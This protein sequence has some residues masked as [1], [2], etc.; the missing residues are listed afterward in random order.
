[1]NLINYFLVLFP[2][3]TWA[4][5]YSL[6][7]DRS[8]TRMGAFLLASLVWGAYLLLG[9]EIL[10]LFHALTLLG[11]LVFWGVSVLVLATIVWR[12]GAWSIPKDVEDISDHWR[13]QFRAWSAGEFLLGGIIVILLVGTFLVAW[14]APPNTNDALQYHLSRVAHWA[15]QASLEHF[16]TPIPRQIWMPP[17]AEMA[18]LHLY[19]LAGGDW[20]VNMVQWLALV[21]CLVAVGEIARQ[22][23][24]GRSGQLLAGLFCVTIP[25]A[26]LQASSAKNDLVLAF[27]VLCLAHFA[28]GFHQRSLKNLELLGACLAVGLGLSTK[29]TFVAYALPFLAWVGVSAL[30][31]RGWKDTVKFAALGL[32][33]VLLLNAGTWARNYGTYG[34]VL[35][36]RDDVAAHANAD[37]RPAAILSNLMLNVALHLP[38]PYG[39]VLNTQLESAFRGVSLALGVEPSP[40]FVMISLWRVED[41]AGNLVHMLL[42][43][44]LSL[45][46]CWPH[47]KVGKHSLQLV[48][49]YAVLV[50]ISM[51]LFSAMYRWQ[52]FG[53]RLQL[54]FFVLWAPLVG[55]II[56]MW[57]YNW[58]RLVV[59]TPLVLSGVLVLL[60]N[61]ARPI[62][63]WQGA[64]SIFQLTRQELRFAN[65]P[66]AYTGYTQT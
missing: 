11:V 55:A 61:Q 52:P 1:M 10:S 21:G 59:V 20:L 2:F 15:Q 24:A 43:I 27:W 58:L 66:W 64:S 65:V 34:A 7:R 53:S 63:G 5:F 44:V 42:I 19:L 36:P 6:L 37:L 48:R 57:R 13:S 35:G 30:R 39:G 31:Q 56:E 14:I 4:L 18:M 40:E 45:W 12:H 22:L 49:G 62:V 50:W 38:V 26:V 3:I 9:T 51:I 33:V 46:L 47:A 28:I 23:G 17:W 25:M 29:G 8:L 54:A 41:S 60:F 32:V 16:A